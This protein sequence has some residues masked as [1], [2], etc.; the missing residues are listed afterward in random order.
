MRNAC[1]AAIAALFL[2]VS[3]V[4]AQDP[5]PTTTP[6]AADR[7]TTPPAVEGQPAAPAAEQPAAPAKEEPA[8]S[9]EA[10]SSDDLFGELD[11]QV[12]VRAQGLTN[13]DRA[14]KFLE[15]KDE[16]IG[17][18]VD[19]VEL[20]SK[21]HEDDDWYFNL[22]ATD[23]GQKDA[24]YGWEFGRYGKFKAEF[25][26]DRI[27]HN[28]A[29][30][31]ET[32]YRG[33][34]SNHLTL[35]D[36]IQ[37]ANQPLATGG[38][39]SAN[40]LFNQLRNQ[41]GGAQ[42]IEDDLF[43]QRDRLRARFEY[44]ALDPI[45]LFA[46]FRYENRDGQKAT[47]GSFGFSNTEELPAPV[48][49]DIYEVEVGVQYAQDDFDAALIYTYSY[50]DSANK[51]LLWDNPLRS[52]D[53]AAGTG[54]GATVG[55]MALEPDNSMHEVALRL[56]YNLP[57]WRTRLSGEVAA[58]WELASS[59]LEP[60]TTNTAATI[61][62]ADGGGLPWDVSSLPDRSFDAEVNTQSYNLTATSNPLD[63]MDIRSVFRFRRQ[64]NDSEEIRFPVFS[65]YDQAVTSGAVSH[66]PHFE[67]DKWTAS[68]DLGYRLDVLKTRIFAGYQ[69][70]EADRQHRDFAQV[71]EHTAR[72]GFE[73]KWSGDLRSRIQYAQTWRSNE[74]MEVIAPGAS[75]PLG[76]FQRFDTAERTRYKPSVSVDWDVTDEIEVSAQYSYILDDYDQYFGLTELYRHNAELDLTW[77]P[78]ERFSFA[79]FFGYE[80]FYVEQT[81][82]QWTPTPTSATAS[83]FN[84]AGN[85]FTTERGDF[86]PSNWTEKELGDDYVVG[87]HTRFEI[88]KERLAVLVDYTFARN[89]SDIDL[90]SPVGLRAATAA[91]GAP[92]D[93]DFVA[94]DD[95]NF[96]I[97]Q[98]LNDA[99][100]SE[101]HTFNMR[102]QWTPSARFMAEVGY[103][104]DEFDVDNYYDD[105]L[106]PIPEDRSGV[107]P[108]WT[109]AVFLNQRV[110]DAEVHQFWISGSYK[111]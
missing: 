60:Y 53:A 13:L 109:G 58:G 84:S 25:G 52:T 96:F 20:S 41:W 67:Y 51:S 77:Q 10:S 18:V 59:D 2:V 4:P 9:E 27:I 45:T 91:G 55:R 69:W 24:R 71:T 87:V 66:L 48:D 68:T 1:F 42:D 7:P 8:E 75:F 101:R 94:G 103:L 99:E 93:D 11:G 32:L 50:F 73:T 14:S 29:F 17:P 21:Q 40:A 78:T 104:Y 83:D 28:Y 19:L 82:R 22:R 43:I 100:N 80:N 3:S 26:W 15:Y 111:F 90:S 61:L 33:V 79:P 65:P 110:E 57:W 102:W 56:G 64:N 38:A 12:V 54:A 23:A 63:E 76:S 47:F 107:V 108:T 92:P 72:G 81:G 6:P 106:N 31:G 36:S 49:A 97:P 85:P 44:Q 5:A 70:D 30:N 95:N 46:E 35:A 88:V 62:P 74:D 34:G 98:D 86:S 37:A 105:G 16:P 39:G 89:K